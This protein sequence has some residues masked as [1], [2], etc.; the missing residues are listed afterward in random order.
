[1][2]DGDKFSWGL[3]GTGSRTLLNLVRSCPDL[4]RLADQA[5]KVITQQF[6]K[7]SIRR[8]VTESFGVLCKS[9]PQLEADAAAPLKAMGDAR[10]ELQEIGRFAGT[11]DFGVVIAHGAADALERLRASGQSYS[12]S[13]LK[14]EILSATTMV[15]LD[16]AVF[17][18]KRNDLMQES[19]RPAS[20]QI[21]YERA[22][23]QAVV[24]RMGVTFDRV[25]EKPDDDAVR[26][27]RRRAQRLEF[28][29]ERLNAPITT[30]LQ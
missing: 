26:A 15:V 3:H 20:D 7:Q 25:L 27:P 1:M 22:L 9:L 19:A 12:R 8:V 16:H 13:E 28:T 29:L 6:K 24:E 21:N 5:A 14:K 23:T 4:E 17:A 18:A 30:T 10:R 11:D 2:P